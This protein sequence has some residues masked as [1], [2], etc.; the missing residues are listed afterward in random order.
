MFLIFVLWSGFG[1]TKAETKWAIEEKLKEAHQSYSEKNYSR[2]RDLLTDLAK[3]FPHDPRFSYFEFMIAKCEYHLKNYDLAYQRFEDFIQEFPK[4]RFIPACYFMR[5]NIEYLWGRRYESAQ[6]FVSAYQMAK[7][8]K[9]TRGLV[10][11]SIK[12]LLQKKLTQ[13][14]VDQLAHQNEDKKLAPKIF[15][16]LGMRRYESRDYDKAE[17]AF[18]YYRD[19]FPNGADIKEVSLFLGRFPSPTSRILKVGVLAPLTGEYSNYGDNM[20]RGINLALRYSFIQGRLELVVKDTEG[21]PLKAASLARELFEDEDM[22]FIIGPLRS[23]ST[24]GV[25][26]AAGEAKIPLISPTASQNGIGGLSEFVFQLSPSNQTKGKSL[27]EFLVK[28]KRLMDFVIFVSEDQDAG[29][30]VQSF[31]EE[32]KRSGAKIVASEYFSKETADFRRSLKRIKKILLEIP[33]SDYLSKEEELLKEIPVKLDGFFILAGKEQML[34][35]L[36]QISFLNIH[37]TVIGME[38]C[39]DREVLNLAK[40]LHQELIFSSDAY[41]F[42]DDHT[43]KSFLALYHNEYNEEPDRVAALSFDSMNLLISVLEKGITNTEN[44]KASLLGV[45]DLDGASGG[46]GFNQQGENQRIP[47]YGCRGGKVERLR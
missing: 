13:K 26:K 29:E 27:A 33:V 15:F 12:P 21:D 37:A 22:V 43:Q 34:K 44:M 6:S 41:R 40:N 10:E 9:T 8:E 35:I 18:R 39:A 7:D 24:M 17:E 47:I 5:G 31:Q 3:S 11:K 36:P 19:N 16:W 30:L 20:L 25:G 45:K 32:A 1:W 46:I 2:S 23:E 38:A 14:E 28:E 42:E 4:S